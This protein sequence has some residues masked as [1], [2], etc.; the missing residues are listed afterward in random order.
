[1]TKPSFL[2]VSQKDTEELGEGNWAFVRTQQLRGTSFSTHPRE[3]FENSLDFWQVLGDFSFPGLC[4]IPT[5]VAAVAGVG[6]VT[7]AAPAGSRWPGP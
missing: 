7:A 4:P 2:A 5:S 1:M 6:A 3:L